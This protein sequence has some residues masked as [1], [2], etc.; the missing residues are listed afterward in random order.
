MVSD[1]PLSLPSRNLIA[2]LFAGDLID[3][4]ELDIDVVLDI[5]KTF[6][7]PVVDSVF[8]YV[9]RELHYLSSRWIALTSELHVFDR[10]DR[11][12][13]EELGKR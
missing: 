13:M 11:S 4:L 10:I 2:H 3:R 6:E 5:V 7:V 8:R 12:S 9:N 1:R